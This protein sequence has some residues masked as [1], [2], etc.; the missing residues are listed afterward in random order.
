[1]T[2]F[3]LTAP[4][5]LPAI[6]A[7]LYGLISWRAIAW[8]GVVAAVGTLGC[9]VVLANQALRGE[10]TAIAIAGLLR[11]DAASAFLIIVLGAVAVLVTAASPAFLHAEAPASAD[12]AR[13]GM[14]TQAML[15][16][17]AL[18]VLAANLGVL[19]VAVEAAVLA[20][21]V[22]LGNGRAAGA[23]WTFL[24][25]CSTGIAL[26]FLGMVLLNQASTASPH[27]STLD[28][29]EL[30]SGAPEFN[31]D[32]TRIAVALLVLGFGAVAGLVPWHGWVSGTHG[33]APAPV[34]ALTS[35]VLLAVACYAILRVKA[36][37]DATLGTGFVRVLLLIM[38]I[39]TL[40][41][42]AALLLAERDHVRMLAQHSMATAGL[43]ALGI[44]V[45]GR[46]AIA[47]VLLHLL[48]HG[49][50]KSVL[51]LGMGRIR[52]LT[53][54]V[55]LGEVRGLVARDPALAGALGIGVLAALAFPPFSPFA[56][57]LAIFRAGF[58]TGAGAVTVVALAMVLVITAT[59]FGR[60]GRLLLGEPRPAL[61]EGPGT[62]TAPA[63]TPAATLAVLTV[64]LTACAALGVTA[65]QLPDLLYLAADVLG[66]SR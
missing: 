35:G 6:C 31:Q 3:L 38:A 58:D 57:E 29:T 19:G 13:F 9:G 30:V 47:A 39:A 16:A 66:G 42:A 17:A 63:R 28:M 50:A 10:E 51:F 65:G 36:I 48:G 12:A 34:A 53:G 64:G 52:Q 1:M 54:G 33:Q 55:S 21:A 11:A 45:G 14:L 56:S 22:L 41:V 59:L 46:L 60:A 2:T 24:V 7:V 8:V 37:A 27:P 15:A 40:A 18:A 4:V 20:T 61:V 49:L 5:L 23:G 43:L 25:V 44:A 32:V 62:A 26:T